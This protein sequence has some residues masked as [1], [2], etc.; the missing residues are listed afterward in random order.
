MSQLAENESN[1]KNDAQQKATSESAAKRDALAAATEAKAATERER[2]AK[3]AVTAKSEEMRKFLSQQYV[4]QGTRAIEDNDYSLAL[5]WF[6]KALEVDEG[7][8]EREPNDRLRIGNTLRA[9]PKMMHVYRHAGPIGY[10]EPSPDGRRIVTASYDDTAR[11]WD[12]ESMGSK[13]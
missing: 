3:L 9:M 6:V 2:E 13:A 4:Q 1:A 11:I 7:D 12:L 5:L 8:P 10:A